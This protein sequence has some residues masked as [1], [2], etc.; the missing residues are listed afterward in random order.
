MSVYSGFFNASNHDRKYDAMD[1]SRLFDGLIRDGIFASIGG[2]FVCTAD[3]KTMTIKVASGRAWFNHTWTYND[4]ILPITISPSEILYHRTDAI[5]LEVNSE[6]KTRANSIKIVKGTPSGQEWQRPALKNTAQVHQYP[7]CYVHLAPAVTS[8]GT[9][10]VENKVGTDATPFV[11]G[12]LEVISI[13]KLI[14]QWKAIL[15]NFVKTNTNN[16]NT[17]MNGEKQ[18]YNK[19]L[20]DSKN[21]Y[22]SMTADQKKRFDAMI[23]SQK[24][25]FNTNEAN[26]TKSFNSQMSSQQSTFETNEANRQSTFDTNTKNQKATFDKALSDAKNSY[27]TWYNSIKNTYEQWF[28]TIKA[29]YDTN[30]AQFQQWEANSKKE[31]DD[32]YAGIKAELDENVAGN[33]QNAVKQL[34][35]DKV[36]LIKLKNGYAADTVDGCLMVGNAIRNLINTNWSASSTFPYTNNGITFTKRNDGSILINGTCTA[37]TGVTFGNSGG[38]TEQFTLEDN[39]KCSCY[40]SDKSHTGYSVGWYTNDNKVYRANGIIPQGSKFRN[41]F[42]SIQKGSSWNNVVI[43]PMLAYNAN[44]TRDMYIPYSGYTIETRPR[45]LIG[46]VGSPGDSWTTNGITFKI[47]WDLSVSVTGTAT[48]TAFFDYDFIQGKKHGI[49]YTSDDRFSAKSSANNNSNVALILSAFTEDDL[50]V[51]TYHTEYTDNVIHGEVKAPNSNLIGKHSRVYLQ[52][53]KGSTV[54]EVFYP[55]R[56]RFDDN[57]P[58]IWSIPRSSSL[59]ITPNTKLPDL[60]LKTF[61]KITNVITPSWISSFYANSDN[62]KYLLDSI[63]KASE[64]SKVTG[65]YTAPTNPEVGDIWIDTM[66]G[67][68][69]YYND[70]KWNRMD[71]TLFVSTEAPANTASYNM[72]YNPSTNQLN[73]YVYA[74]GAWGSP[75]WYPVGGQGVA[76]VNVADANSSKNNFIVDPNTGIAQYYYNGSWHKVTS[77]WS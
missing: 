28:A 15:D 66:K 4:N 71:T 36:S 65:A 74:G 61:D 56:T 76:I 75:G 68:P 26:R 20:E 60:S 29:A 3:G 73:V 54:S 21:A 64:S 9:A 19:W 1:I 38:T 51:N 34:Q 67:I 53:S 13:D 63:K 22:N 31:F 48:E 23:E 46:P 59:K 18:T 27:N 40:I 37:D 24:S 45:N 58:F 5:V 2:C 16:F 47:N 52:V 55:M 12:I 32:W 62:G 11:S 41:V 8:I 72:W 17:W 25:T 14:P 33:L 7:L 42:I 50:N 6:E 69:Y 30:W 44:I 39:A 57:T 10:D 49:K 77:V 43:L 70:S 35:S